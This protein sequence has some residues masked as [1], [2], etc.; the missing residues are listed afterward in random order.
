MTTTGMKKEND[1]EFAYTQHKH[2]QP[3][4]RYGKTGK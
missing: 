3:K 2:L 1:T 4:R